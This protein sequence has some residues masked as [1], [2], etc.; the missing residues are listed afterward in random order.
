MNTYP[1]QLKLTT[2]AGFFQ[3]I[4]NYIQAQFRRDTSKKTVKVRSFFMAGR[5]SEK[6][7]ATIVDR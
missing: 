7:L 6:I 3:K 5:K 4:F 1:L 2:T